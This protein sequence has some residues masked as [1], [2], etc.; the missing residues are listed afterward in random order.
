LIFILLLQTWRKTPSC[1]V[2]RTAGFVKELFDA[3]D[4]ILVVA[5]VAS[6]VFKRGAYLFNIEGCFAVGSRD[7][8]AFDVGEVGAR[9]SG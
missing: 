9:C 8:R 6:P 1:P 2:Y 3:L 4:Q 7:V 5:A